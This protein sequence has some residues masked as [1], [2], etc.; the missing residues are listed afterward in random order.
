MSERHMAPCGLDCARCDIFV[1]TRADSDELREQIAAK[2]TE[3]FHYPFQKD[4]INCDGCLG[5]GRL[6]IYCR[7]RCDIRP[8][9]L[10]RGLT[11]CERCPDYECDKLKANRAASAAY[12]P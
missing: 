9:A 4:D 6:G 3:L 12:T 2:W 1:A 8:C 10:E 7:T 5:G 11:L